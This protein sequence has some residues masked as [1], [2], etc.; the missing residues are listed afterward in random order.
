MKSPKHVINVC[1]L[2]LKVSIG[3]AAGSEGVYAR[4]GQGILQKST[5]SI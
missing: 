1:T 4:A 5:M 3:S 2:L